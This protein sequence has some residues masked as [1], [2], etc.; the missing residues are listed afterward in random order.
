MACLGLKVRNDKLLKDF[1]PAF[2]P[3]V[4]PETGK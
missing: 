4:S 2:K 1:N 3:A